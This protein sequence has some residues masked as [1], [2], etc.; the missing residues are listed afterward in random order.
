MGRVYKHILVCMER[1]CFQI[2]GRYIFRLRLADD[3]VLLSADGEVT[4]TEKYKCLRINMER[5]T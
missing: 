3:V 1:R 5:L 2:D 4:N